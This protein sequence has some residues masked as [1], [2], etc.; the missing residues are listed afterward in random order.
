MGKIKW[1]FYWDDTPPSIVNKKD[2][3][4][5]KKKHAKNNTNWEKST[6]KREKQ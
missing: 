3:P 1:Q 2:K 4:K 6:D 5:K